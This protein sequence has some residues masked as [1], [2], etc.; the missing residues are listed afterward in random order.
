MVREA[1]LDPTSLH[2]SHFVV[3]VASSRAEDDQ[4]IVGI[5]QIRPYPGCPELGSMVVLPAYRK[6]GIGGQIIRAL[7]ASHP[8]PIFLE[9]IANKQTYYSRFGFYLIP[10]YR[11]P[12]PLNLKAGMGTLIA[13]LLRWREGVIVMRWDGVE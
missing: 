9:A 7:Q 3:A 13:R 6:R 2:W 12:F 4:Q 5:G 10:W 8:P 1:G 11:A